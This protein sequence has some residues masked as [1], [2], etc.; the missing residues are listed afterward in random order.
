MGKTAVTQQERAEDNRRQRGHLDQSGHSAHGC[1]DLGPEHVG[2]R[3]G[4]DGGDRDQLYCRSAYRHAEQVKQEFREDDR[5]CG[6]GRGRRDQH[7]E[8]AK[9]ERGG[10]AICL[11]Q[12]H[13]DAARL[14]QQRAQFRH[15][16]RAAN[17]DQTEGRP[18]SHDDERIG[19]EPGDGGGCAEDPAADREADDQRRAAGEPDDAP[20]L[21]RR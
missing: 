19:D 15:R 21:V 17:A 1:A 18:E 10:I 11:A 6:D 7:I 3:E 9:D 20:E 5:E 8:P 16:E 13:V 2:E 14:G 12:E 4:D